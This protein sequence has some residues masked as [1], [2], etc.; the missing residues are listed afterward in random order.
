MLGMQVVLPQA[1]V[2]LLSTVSW[3]QRPF[4]LCS[5]AG[6]VSTV[7]LLCSGVSVLTAAPVAPG[8]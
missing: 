7:T 5:H 8:W 1:H 2:M 3:A 4:W 6:T